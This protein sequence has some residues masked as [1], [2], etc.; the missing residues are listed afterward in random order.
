MLF[1]KMTSE[2][3]KKLWC[4]LG[5]YKLSHCKK[6]LYTLNVSISQDEERCRKWVQNNRLDDLRAVPIQKLGHYQLCSRHF[7]DSQFM[8]KET[9]KSTEQPVDILQHI[10]STSTSKQSQVCDTPKKKRLKPKV[11]ALRTKLWGKKQFTKPRNKAAIDSL[12]AQYTQV[13]PSQTLCKLWRHSSVPYLV[14]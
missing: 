11:Q 8:N 12:V 10:P 5:S 14:A 2:A 1:I 4:L 9:V 3:S 6:K 13:L 7:E